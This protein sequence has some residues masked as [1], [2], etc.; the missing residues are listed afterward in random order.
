M[1]ERAFGVFVIVVLMR[2]FNPDFEDLAATYSP[3]S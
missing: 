2:I 1:F 3:A